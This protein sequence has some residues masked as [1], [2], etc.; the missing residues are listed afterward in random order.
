[1]HDHD[2]E[3]NCSSHHEKGLPTP[4]PTLDGVSDS[5]SHN[6]AQQQR[7][8]VLRRLQTATVL[9]LCFMTIEVI[10]GFWAGSLAVLSDAAHLLADTASFAIAIVANYLARMPST[11]THT[12]GLQR[13]ESLAALFSMVSLAIVCVGLASEA[14]RRLYH[15]VMQD[16]AA[17]ELLNVDGRLMS[18]IATIG[19]CVNIVL[20]LVLGE[21]HVHL[22]SY[23]DSHGHDHHHDHVHPATES[24]ALLPKSTNGDVEHCVI[25]NDEA[26]PDKARNVN[27]HAAYLH[28]LGDLAQSVAVLIAGIVIWLKPSWAIVD[29]IC[30]LG[31][32][33]L[34]FY[35]TLGVLRSSIA[36]L[37]EE[38]PPHVSWQDVYDD[39][40]E[41][42]SL[43][44]VHDLHIWCISDGVTV[45]SLHASAVDGHVDQALRDVNR[46]CQKHK[47]QHITA[48]LQTASVEECITCTQSNLNCKS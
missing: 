45:V 10:G 5:G 22:P 39:L 43:T 15:I 33:G 24:S 41:L 18:G 28:V 16:D 31:F 27:L 34:V 14:S 35:S 4:S 11:V 36:V 1:M 42:E 32:C 20:A 9:C 6:A 19:V 40:S 38:V 26:V 46:V 25:H 21:H 47:L 29:P 23:G 17:E 30:T 37:L 2:H 3:H 12:Y 8:Q 44:K 7:L 13:T 48:Q